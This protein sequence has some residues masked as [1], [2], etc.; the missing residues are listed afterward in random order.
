MSD[1]LTPEEQA[2]Q[3]KQTQHVLQVAS[4]NL[5]VVI[6]QLQSLGEPSVEIVLEALDTAHTDLAKLI[7]I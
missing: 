3:A 6:D 4:T 7:T 5:D 2:E 1:T